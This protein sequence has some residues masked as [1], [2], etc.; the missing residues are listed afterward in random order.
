VERA[1]KAATDTVEAAAAAAAADRSSDAT[2]SSSDDST[3]TAVSAA[4]ETSSSSASSSAEQLSTAA[5]AGLRKALEAGLGRTVP[6][7][8][9]SE[10]QIMFGLDGSDGLSSLADRGMLA[11]ALSAVNLGLGSPTAAD[12]AS[13]ATGAA[14]GGGDGLTLGA[15]QGEGAEEGVTAE[16]WLMAFSQLD[17][18]DRGVVT[19]EDLLRAFVTTTGTT[20]INADGNGDGEQE[21]DGEETATSA[22]AS[23]VVYTGVQRNAIA[24]R[25]G[26]GGVEGR[27]SA[28]VG[29]L[30]ATVSGGE[31]QVTATQWAEAGLRLSIDVRRSVIELLPGSAVDEHAQ[32]AGLEEEMSIVIE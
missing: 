24:Q 13:T 26:S 21:Q 19:C 2:T 11:A 3:T 12:G 14:G 20:I 7:A 6:E 4:V 10:L 15:G 9:V 25:D 30:F 29:E 28:V 18:D 32:L 31:Q 23:S 5:A 27:E 22:D 17:V 8:T 1:F 16:S